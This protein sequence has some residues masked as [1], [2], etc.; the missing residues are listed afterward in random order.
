V[1]GLLTQPGEY[2]GVVSQETDL[3]PVR[4]QQTAL[5]SLTRDAAEN[6]VSGDATLRQ[7]AARLSITCLTVAPPVIRAAHIE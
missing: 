2:P 1:P 3:A 5:G 4:G 6:D 7:L